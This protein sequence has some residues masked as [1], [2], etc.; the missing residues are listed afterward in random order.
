MHRNKAT[1]SCKKKKKKGVVKDEGQMRF[2]GC[3]SDP[4]F[5]PNYSV[6]H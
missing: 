4:L 6:Q 5:N 1:D 3:K 2:S